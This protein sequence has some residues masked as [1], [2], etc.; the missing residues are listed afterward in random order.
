[1]SKS[2]KIFRN[3]YFG[4]FGIKQRK[5]KH[6]SHTSEKIHNFEHSHE[7][8]E[9]IKNRKHANQL[10]CSK[11]AKT[12]AS[13]VPQEHRLEE[14]VLGLPKSARYHFQANPEIFDGKPL[15]GDG[16]RPPVP[17]QVVHRR[18]G[19]QPEIQ[20]FRRLLEILFKS[21]ELFICSL[22]VFE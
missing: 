17:N 14:E 22:F 13:R 3:P 21:D 8:C 20:H 11:K 2:T 4:I 12:S 16:H 9:N 1:M 18:N 7:I 10:R 5:R 19:L 15:A 6:S